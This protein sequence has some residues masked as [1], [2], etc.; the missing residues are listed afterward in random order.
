MGLKD[1]LFSQRARVTYWS[2]V[3]AFLLIGL[4]NITP[5]AGLDSTL[6][7][8]GEVDE[9]NTM[10]VDFYP[11]EYV[12]TEPFTEDNDDTGVFGGEINERLGYENSGDYF[13]EIGEIGEELSSR[14]SVMTTLSVIMLIVGFSSRNNR[15]NANRFMNGK[16]LAG[17]GLAIIALFSVLITSTISVSYTHLTLPTILLV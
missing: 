1:K 16:T 10:S 14:I 9:E 11:D 17:I 2:P 5:F 3:V 4:L 15:L 8:D 7:I 6:K 12:E 13:G